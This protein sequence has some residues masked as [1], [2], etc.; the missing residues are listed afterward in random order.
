[1]QSED[2]FPP[3]LVC[4]SIEHNDHKGVYQSIE[5]YVQD[6][7]EH[8]DYP[9]RFESAEHFRRSVETDE[10]WAVRWYPNTPVGFCIVYAP[11]LDEAIAYAKKVAA[12]A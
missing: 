5:D 8:M 1:M 10:L 7:S 12:R 6:E 2:L 9:V 4:A 11:T 3:H